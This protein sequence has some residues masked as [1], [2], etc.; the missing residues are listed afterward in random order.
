MME[1]STKTLWS[2]ELLGET[3]DF[4]YLIERSQKWFGPKI[5][6]EPYEEG[7][8][9]ISF[10]QLSEFVEKFEVF[11]EESG[12]AE[13]E[14]VSTLSHNSTVLVLLFLAIVANRRVFVPINPNCS[15]EEINYIINDS[16]PK[17][18]IYDL[19]FKKK[20]FEAKNINHKIEIGKGSEFIDQV[21]S[22][23][24]KK[25]VL[26]PSTEREFDAQI[27]YTSGTTGDPKGVLLTHE[28]LI[29]DLFGIG[30]TFNF[31]GEE[32]FLTVC[33]LFH[34]SGQI[35]TTLVPL[36][37]GS[38]TTAIPS[39]TGF[40]HFCYYVDRFDISWSLGMPAHINLILQLGVTLT[41]KTLRGLLCGGAKLEDERRSEFEKKFSTIVYN[42]YG[43]TESTSFATCEL[44]GK[45]QRVSGS[46]GNPL[47]INEIKI[48]KEDREVLP[49]ELGEVR[50]KGKNIFKEYLNKPEI[51]AEKKKDGWFYTGD[52]GFLDQQKNL[53]IVDRIDNMIL[54]GGEN[55]FPTE[56][57]KF[58]PALKGI[59]D[60]VLSSIPHSILG[61]EL[62]L[63]YETYEK[64]S[65]DVKK[66]KEILFQRLSSYKVPKQ[67][68]HVTDLGIEKI[69][70]AA[71]GKVLRKKLKDIVAES[72]K[73]L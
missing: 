60:G 55:V 3:K 13:G 44:P 19:P 71:N 59:K 30:S 23:K 17:T 31:A 8:S 41:K 25:S 35:L 54:V 63:I 37:C 33:P 20:A 65:V 14:K 67:I 51:T 22:I 64:T 48:F 18:L 58:I 73:T 15:V 21:F 43:A 68:V 10:Q 1:R 7:I 9:A 66:W 27:V 57:E 5:F 12:I 39:D 24:L 36:W 26:P 32:N 4:R 40:L 42:N 56:V 38:R 52:I 28:N 49:N 46:V 2:K 62:V 34:N 70:R 69:P 6:L 72:L 45:K 50:I 47:N 61:S 29:T 53:V 16:K 11:L